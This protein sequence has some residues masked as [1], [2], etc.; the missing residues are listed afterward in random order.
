[1]DPSNCEAKELCE[2]GV[3]T[4]SVILGNPDVAIHIHLRSRAPPAWGAASRSNLRNY[5][6]SGFLKV[7][8]PRPAAGSSY[9]SQVAALLLAYRFP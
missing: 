6:T 7:E 3:G 5:F 9:V 2:D 8:S 4:R 1:M